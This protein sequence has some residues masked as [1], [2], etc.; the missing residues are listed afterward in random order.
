MTHN[1]LPV[2]M[3]NGQ[4]FLK[5]LVKIPMKNIILTF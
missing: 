4:I 3:L 2:F 5:T 1:L